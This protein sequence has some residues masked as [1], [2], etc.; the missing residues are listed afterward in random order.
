MSNPKTQTKIEILL[1]IEQKIVL[2]ELERD[3]LDHQLAILKENDEQCKYLFGKYDG[4]EDSLHLLRKI[5]KR[6]GKEKNKKSS[7]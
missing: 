6:N 1:E 3:L 5:L 4:L 2:L 7:E